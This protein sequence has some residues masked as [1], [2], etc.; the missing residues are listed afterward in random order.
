MFTAI[1]GRGEPWSLLP[2]RLVV[3]L[4]VRAH[5]GQQLLYGGHMTRRRNRSEAMNHEP[6]VA[7]GGQRL[8]ATAGLHAAEGMMLVGEVS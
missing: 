4:L 5:A 3:G 6:G 8:G 7:A 1:K 2:L